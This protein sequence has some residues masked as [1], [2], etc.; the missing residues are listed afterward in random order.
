GCGADSDI[1]YFGKAFLTEALNRTTSIPDA[2]AQAKKSVD[3]WETADH[4]EHSEPQI[5]STRS[6]EAKLEAWRRTLK[7]GAPVPFAPAKAS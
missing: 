2:F 1:T 6:I 5:A 7:P 3:A 4:E